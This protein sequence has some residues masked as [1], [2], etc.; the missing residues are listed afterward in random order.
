VTWRRRPFQSLERA[1]AEPRAIERLHAPEDLDIQ[2]NES[3]VLHV[4]GISTPD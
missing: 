4:A 2:L 1:I 3:G